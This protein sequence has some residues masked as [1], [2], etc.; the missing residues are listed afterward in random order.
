MNKHIEDIDICRYGF[1]TLGFILA[2]DKSAQR[3]AYEKGCLTTFSNIVEMHSE[4]EELC[5]LCNELISSF[6][7]LQKHEED[8][9]EQENR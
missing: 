3:E 7:S 5:E 6:L 1:V 4:D 8:I 9:E 2:S